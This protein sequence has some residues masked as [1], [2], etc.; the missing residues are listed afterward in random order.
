MDPMEIDG[1]AWPTGCEP[2][3]DRLTDGGECR[4]YTGKANQ[5]F[6]TFLLEKSS[7]CPSTESESCQAPHGSR[8]FPLPDETFREGFQFKLGVDFHTFDLS[9]TLSLGMD[10]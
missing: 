9:R 6:Q 4:V 10:R 3:L 8:R 1:P 5:I 2:D 7:Q